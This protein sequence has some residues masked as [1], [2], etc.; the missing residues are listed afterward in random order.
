MEAADLYQRIQA[1][2][3][4]KLF[5]NT[6]KEEAAA[7][8]IYLTAKGVRPACIPFDGEIGGL[9]ADAMFERLQKRP[10]L[11]K[12]LKRIPEIQV[13]KGP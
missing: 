7:L 9:S 1:A 12:D 6:V 5:Q 2:I 13:L 4:K 3:P 10:S 11:L 8:D